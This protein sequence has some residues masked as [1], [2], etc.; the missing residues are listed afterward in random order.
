VELRH[1]SAYL[2]Q[3]E[4]DV[5]AIGD[6]RRQAAVSR[7]GYDSSSPCIEAHVL[8]LVLNE[9][10]KLHLLLAIR[11]G[12]RLRLGPKGLGTIFVHFMDRDAGFARRRTGRRAA[13][14]L[15]AWERFPLA[16][17]ASQTFVDENIMRLGRNGYPQARSEREGFQVGGWLLMPRLVLARVGPD[18][19]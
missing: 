11:A 7:S 4:F 12:K 3:L 10:G 1:V 14:E 9:R 13:G 2:A 15:R 19:A 5:G 16:A 18:L 6:S 17:E 8:R